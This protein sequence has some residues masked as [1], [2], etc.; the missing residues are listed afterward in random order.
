MRPG[1]DEAPSIEARLMPEAAALATA[2]T[3]RIGNNELAAAIDATRDAR[4]PEARMV[5]RTARDLSLTVGIVMADGPFRERGWR[6]A[7]SENRP[8]R[9]EATGRGGIVA[10]DRSPR[11]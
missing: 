11:E 10:T 4:P 3:V 9:R 1:R 5:L 6:S 7:R 2:S 8:S